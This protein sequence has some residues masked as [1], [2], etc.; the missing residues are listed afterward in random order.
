MR[1]QQYLASVC[2]EFASWS[3][4]G[5]PDIVASSLIDRTP[6]GGGKSASARLA[7]ADAKSMKLVIGPFGRNPG[8]VERGHIDRNGV[9]STSGFWRNIAAESGCG[10]SSEEYD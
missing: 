7:A 2:I 6:I 1:S 9:V 8:L 10:M 5:S 3:A 4:E